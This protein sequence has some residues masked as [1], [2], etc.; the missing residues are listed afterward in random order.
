M[1]K[2]INMISLDPS[3]SIKYQQDI[4]RYLLKNIDDAIGF[5]NSLLGQLNWAF[6]EFMGLLKEV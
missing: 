3:P 5:L 6:S 4:G 1:N 2:V